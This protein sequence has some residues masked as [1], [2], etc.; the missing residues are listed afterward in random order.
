MI[1][2]AQ[3]NA[4]TSV[5]MPSAEQGIKI[6]EALKHLFGMFQTASLIPFT[7]SLTPSRFPV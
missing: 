7:P 1:H 5:H 6:L 4:R 3:F 2:Q